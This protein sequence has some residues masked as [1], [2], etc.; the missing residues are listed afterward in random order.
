MSLHQATSV[1]MRLMEV[2]HKPRE[3]ITG[4]KFC[5]LRNLLHPTRKLLRAR[6]NGPAHGADEQSNGPVKTVGSGAS[7]RMDRPSSAPTGA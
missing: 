7:T 1:G 3:S 2:I 4:H 6:L 5:S